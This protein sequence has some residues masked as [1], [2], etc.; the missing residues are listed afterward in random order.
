MSPINP[1]ITP[2]EEQ[3]GETACGARILINSNTPYIHYRDEIVYF[4]GQECKQIYDEDPLNS[5]LAA[6]LLAGQ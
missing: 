4:C 5:C 6:R 1:S 2:S 3:G